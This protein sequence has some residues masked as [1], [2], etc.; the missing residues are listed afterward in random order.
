[1]AVATEVLALNEASQLERNEHQR[2]LMDLEA[3]KRAA[4]VD[5]PTLP[6]DVRDALRGMGLPVRLFGENLANVRDRL[7]L[8]LARYEVAQEKGLVFEEMIPVTSS[9]GAQQQQQQSAQEE[10]C[11]ETEYTT[12]TQELLVAREKISKFSFERAQQRL[13]TERQHRRQWQAK[14]VRTVSPD[15]SDKEKKDSAETDVDRIDDECWEYFKKCK[16]MGLQGSQYGDARAMSSICASKG[17]VHGTPLVATGSWSGTIKLWDGS[18]PELSMVGQKN[19]CHE[20]RIMNIAM[21]SKDENAMLA[22]VSVDLSAKL[23]NVAPTDVSMSDNDDNEN[24]NEDGGDSPQWSITEA[25]HLKGHAARLSNVAFHPMGEHVATTSFDHTWRLWD[26]ETGSEILLQDGHWKEVYGIGFHPDGSMCSTTDFGG[27]IQCWD[28]RIGKSIMHFMGHA[29]RVICAEF[30]PNGFQLSTSG[31]DG[32]I[33]IWD[34]RKKKQFVSVPAHSNIVTQ[35]KFGMS[36]HGR[37][38]VLASSSF[39]GTVKLWSARDWK[40]LST[41]QGHEG[42]VM[43]VDFSHDDCL[44]SCGFDKTLKMWK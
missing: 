39:D 36:E 22:T 6:K 4:S 44:V 18:S 42:K 14:R 23:W 35:L 21:Q 24:Q 38:E 26:I 9:S 34:L 29:K 32:T 27:V 25:A 3:Q 2:M 10:E 41:M 5:V 13:S 17:A 30:S 1:V 28:M 37:G 7:R 15:D 11:A 16:A 33:K 31:D 40:I 19:V 12:A 43:G 20:D 8:E